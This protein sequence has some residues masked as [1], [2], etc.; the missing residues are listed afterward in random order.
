[1]DPQATWDDLLSAYAESDWDRVEE[2]ADALIRWLECGGFPP[3]AVTGSDMNQ[4]WDRTIA[5]AGCRFALVQARKGGAV[6]ST[7]HD[8]G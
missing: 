7:R 5:L 1:M 3:R 2:L 4:D 6:C 8:D